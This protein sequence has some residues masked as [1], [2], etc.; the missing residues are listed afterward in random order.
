[1]VEISF[2]IILQTAHI[3]CIR[4]KIQEKE[5]DQYE[6]I[7]KDYDRYDAGACPGGVYSLRRKHR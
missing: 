1:M 2:D 4:Y 3:I 6:K 5:T 7:K